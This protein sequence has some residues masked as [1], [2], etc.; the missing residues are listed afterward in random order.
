MLKSLF[1]KIEWDA[2]QIV[3]FDMD[4]TLYDELDFIIQVYQPIA[5]HM[6]SLCLVEPDMIYP[7]I[8]KRWL[9]K[10]SS[11]PYIFEEVLAQHHVE[12]S[13]RKTAISECLNI[14][15]NFKPQLILTERVQILLDA[16]SRQYELFLISDGSANLQRA[17]FQ[18]LGLDRWFHS[19]NVAFSG[20]FGPQFQKPS[21]LI[22]EKIR[23]LNSVANPEEVVFLGDRRV[24][25]EFA[26]KARY[27]FVGVKCLYCIDDDLC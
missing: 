25:C 9:E 6:A 11:Y 7:M 26:S 14:F 5:R 15:R 19:K 24:D 21:T 4:G 27:Q 18:S 1:P 23:I 17:K 22:I 2:I 3:G 13:I 16:F 8:V 10:G 20:C 12:E